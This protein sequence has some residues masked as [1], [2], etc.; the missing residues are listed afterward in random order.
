[1]SRYS[2]LKENFEKLDKDYTAEVAKNLDLQYQFDSLKAEYKN[3]RNQ[4]QEIERLHENTRRLK[5]DM[6][7]HIMVIASH[8]NNNEVEKAK[9]YLSVV[10]DNLNRVYSYIQTGNSVLNYIINSKLEYAQQNGIQFKAEIENLL[11]AKMGSVDFSAVL[12]N[13]LDNA[14]EASMQIAEKFIY[15][16]ILKKRGYDTITVKNK[17]EKSV[18]EENPDLISTKAESETHGYGVK[19]IKSITEK[20]DGIVDIYEDEGMFCINIMIPSE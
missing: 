11:F 4:Q 5:H 1:M 8:L 15:V 19:Q 7:N 6:K 14:I 20:Y 3:S 12:S 9:E 17:I 18:L 13:A 16:S 10:L 2:K